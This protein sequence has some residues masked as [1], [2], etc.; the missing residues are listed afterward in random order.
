MKTEITATDVVHLECSV[1]GALPDANGVTYL[2]HVAKHRE[3]LGCFYEIY[4]DVEPEM[5]IVREM[6]EKAS[7]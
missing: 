5:P 4:V 3:D 7:Q 1:H 6:R 2:S